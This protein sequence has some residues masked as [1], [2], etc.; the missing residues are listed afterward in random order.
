MIL[1]I[2]KK[3]EVMVITRQ[4]PR[5]GRPMSIS[6]WS[7]DEDPDSGAW[8]MKVGYC[9]C[10]CG[11]L[12]FIRLNEMREIVDIMEQHIDRYDR[13]LPKLKPR[14]GFKTKII[15]LLGGQVG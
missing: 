10:G 9:A 12:L 8:G 2:S 5:G 1:I 7:L 11:Q 15:R 6:S 3:R 13:V 14:E 4:N